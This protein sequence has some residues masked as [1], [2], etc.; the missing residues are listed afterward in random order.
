MIQAKYGVAA[1]AEGQFETC[2]S[3]LLLSTLLPFQTPKEEGW[4]SVMNS[5]SEVS[6][7][8]YRAIIE[9]PKFDSYFLHVTP[10]A[11]LSEITLMHQNPFNGGNQNISKQSFCRNVFLLTFFSCRTIAWIFPWT[12]SRHI[13]PSWLGFGAALQK[14]IDD[15][16][17]DLLHRM[18]R[19]W[20]LF[21]SM[22]DLIEMILAKVDTRI[23]AVYD[24]TLVS[25]P[26]EKSIGQKIFESYDETVRTILIVT[27]HSR[28]CEHNPFLR[29]LILL[30]N[31]FLDPINILQVQILKEMRTKAPITTLKDALMITVNGIAAGMR[32][33]G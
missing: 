21:H 29:H 28:L 27:G 1:V 33:T 26:E 12:Q 23:A 5:L 4:Q 7:Q 25:D 17:L 11:E 3:A 16:K 15:G 20:P 19:E 2:A 6:C 14:A 13:F 18:Y 24:E 9:H 31:P 32:N 8:E 22:V 10:K 30:R